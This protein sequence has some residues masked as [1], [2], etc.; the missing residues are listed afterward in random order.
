MMT[1]LY[2]VAIRY[3]D[4]SG[5]VEY[6]QQTKNFKVELS[7]E[8]K[9]GEVEAYLTARH[10]LRKQGKGLLDFTEVEIEP[11]ASVADLKLALTRLWHTTEVLVDWSR[12][13]A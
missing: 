8:V 1:E 4:V 12:P 5:Y 2:R 10:K 13:V 9:R 7:D 11:T 6:D 3:L